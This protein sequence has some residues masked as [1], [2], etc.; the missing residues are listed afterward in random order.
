[1]I[2]EGTAF[3]EDDL[4]DNPGTNDIVNNV[5]QLMMLNPTYQMNSSLTWV[6]T[7]C[8]LNHHT[9]IDS[10]PNHTTTLKLPNPHHD[11]DSTEV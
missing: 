6:L 4:E 7:G 9:H 2:E 8:L 11:T 3:I 10:V 1:M 5:L